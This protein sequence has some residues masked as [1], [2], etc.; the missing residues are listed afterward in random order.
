MTLKTDML[1]IGGGMAG[2]CAALELAEAG[3]EVLLLEKMGYAGGSSAMSGGCLA[4]AGT[5]LQQK[6]GIED[7]NDLLTKDLREVGQQK[8]DEG[9]IKAYV[10]NQLETYNWLCRHGVEF[11][12]I[13]ATLSGQS[14]PRAHAL[15]P[16]DTIRLLEARCK[17]TGRVTVMLSARAER[18]VYDEAVAR[19]QGVRVQ[20]PSGTQTVS[21]TGQVILASGGFCQ[22]KEMV[23]RFAPHYAE[24]VFVGGAGNVGDG[25]RMAWKLGADVRDMAHIKGTYGK[26]PID[27]TNDHSCLAAYKGA[28]IVNQEGKRYVDESLSYKLLGDAC[29]AQSDHTTYQIFDQPIF[30]SGDDRVKILDFGRRLEEGTLLKADTL[31]ELAQMIDIPYGVLKKTLDTY[32]S[33]VDAGHDPDFG[34]KALVHHHGEL[35]RVETGPFFAYPST[36]VIFGTYCGLRIDAQMHVLDVFGD[37]I[38]GLLAAG[39][40]VGGFHGGAYM[41]GTSLGKAA[42]FGRVAARTALAESQPREE[43]QPAPRGEAVGASA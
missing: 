5:A 34:R 28:V 23:R 16:A 36:A 26:H 18:F 17:A 1:V 8:G 43:K 37:R 11:S 9:L 42:I 41:T 19:V 15:D 31:Q 27:M 12:P 40:V 22:D 14:V 4:L 24:A 13:V 20:T 30:E 35:V 33:Y 2:F 39:E 3:R 10:D 29:M 25:L 38:G 6:N 32:N 21:V 7:S